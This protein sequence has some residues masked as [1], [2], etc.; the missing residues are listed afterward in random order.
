MSNIV[1][2]PDQFGKAVMKSIAE[3]GDRT[4]DMV[5]SVTKNT[6]RQTV[7]QLK[8]S[9]PA[10]GQYARGWSHKPQKGGRYS[11]SDTVYNRTDYMLT[12]LLE[13]PHVT[14]GGSHPVGHYPKNVDYTG[15]IARVE[16][17]FSNKYVEEVMA[18][19]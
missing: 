10:G 13:K 7:K 9:A 11:L 14:G 3:Y 1:V 6:A 8:A 18:K 4:L 19:L 2:T 15:T 12:H 17:E 5:E 16:E